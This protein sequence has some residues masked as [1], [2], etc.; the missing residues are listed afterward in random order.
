MVSSPLIFIYLSLLNRYG[1]K[2][3]PFLASPL[4]QFVQARE[5]RSAIL[6]LETDCCHHAH[7]Q[8]FPA[9]PSLSLESC[10]PFPRLIFHCPRVAAVVSPILSMPASFDSASHPPLY[11]L[12]CSLFCIV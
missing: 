10:G 7:P 2:S 11:S 1:R 8:L 4:R 6:L 9:S 3:P 12:L 5:S